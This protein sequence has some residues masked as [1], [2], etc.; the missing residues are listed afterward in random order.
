MLIQNE[1]ENLKNMIL[2]KR[3][4]PIGEGCF[5]DLEAVEF[6]LLHF[7][8]SS[9]IAYCK[10]LSENTKNYVN[11]L[12]DVLTSYHGIVVPE[13]VPVIKDPV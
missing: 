7:P 10:A 6:D 9:L 11:Q 1:D 3:R 12:F 13:T 8:K 2:F 5:F 4:P